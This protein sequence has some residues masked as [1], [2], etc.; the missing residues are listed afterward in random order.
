MDC[1]FE[2]MAFNVRHSYYWRRGGHLKVTK[3]EASA[4]LLPTHPAL[5][6]PLLKWKS[7][8]HNRPE[9]FVFPS[10]R[11]KRLKPLD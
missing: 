2:A 1:D 6:Q 5:K 4:G 7:Q 3:T 9:D 8:S 10:H 11:F